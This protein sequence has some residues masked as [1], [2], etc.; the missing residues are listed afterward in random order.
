MLALDNPRDRRFLANTIYGRLS[1][2]DTSHMHDE[3]EEILELASRLTLEETSF[4]FLVHEAPG[5]LE[6]QAADAKLTDAIQAVLDGPA[7]DLG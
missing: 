2:N 1:Y 6:Q 4:G 3:I 5:T 7:D